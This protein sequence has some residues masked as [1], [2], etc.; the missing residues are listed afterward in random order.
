MANVGTS[1]PAPSVSTLNKGNQLYKTANEDTATQT[2]ESVFSKAWAEV[3]SKNVNRTHALDVADDILKVT[4]IPTEIPDNF[5]PL[6]A[7]LT[8]LQQALKTSKETK[9]E[10]NEEKALRKETL[11]KEFNEFCRTM[12]NLLPMHLQSAGSAYL[13]DILEYST[14]I[15][16]IT[17]MDDDKASKMLHD[18]GFVCNGFVGLF[19]PPKESIKDPNITQLKN[20]LLNLMTIGAYYSSDKDLTEKMYRAHNVILICLITVTSKTSGIVGSDLARS[21]GYISFINHLFKT[22]VIAGDNLKALMAGAPLPFIAEYALINALKSWVPNYFAKKQMDKTPSLV[23]EATETADSILLGEAPLQVD[24]TSSP[25]FEMDEA[26]NP[27]NQLYYISVF[28]PGFKNRLLPFGEVP[29][30]ALTHAPETRWEYMQG[31][32]S[33]T[34]QEIRNSADVVEQNAKNGI[35]AAREADSS[36][37]GWQDYIEQI[38]NGTFKSPSNYRAVNYINSWAHYR[39]TGY[40]NN[41]RELIDRFF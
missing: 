4:T 35:T 7:A 24:S 27:R 25:A 8:K 21:E 34:R 22:S 23:G 10:T 30:H 13:R 11:K 5:K 26:I 18:M 3:T 20:S 16:N 38:D 28:K 31:K 37:Y 2:K 41:Q 39:T 1:T 33:G 19:F 14:L 17:E 40:E 9:K 29:G 36:K 6:T 15:M 12:L 32:E